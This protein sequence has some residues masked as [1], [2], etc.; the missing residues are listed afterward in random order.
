MVPVYDVR[1][2]FSERRQM[3][4]LIY[5]WRLME[6]DCQAYGLQIEKLQGENV[7]ERRTY[8]GG[9]DFKYR[10]KKENRLEPILN[11]TLYWE[12]KRWESPLSLG[13]MTKIRSLPLK[14]CELF[15]NYRIHLIHMRSIPEE[16]L[17]KMDSDL[18]YV[19]GLMK[20][21]SSRK[22]YEGLIMENQ[23]YFSRIPK[24]AVDVIDVCTSI[25]NIRKHLQFERNGEG[26]E[27]ADMCK[28][29]NEIERHAEKQGIKKGIKQGISQGITQGIS[30]GITQ[31]ESRFASLMEKLFADDRMEDAKLAAA[32]D[33]AR[34]LFYQEYGIA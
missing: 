25:K 31:G 17:Q 23:E 22:K 12:K 14:L 7:N 34:K 15:G 21:T 2:L 20:R 19:L 11:L 4:K 18:K 10:Y 27:E 28:A 32:D 16:E 29:L 9:D 26:E 24:S 6:L 8:E 3:K 13:E 33:K 1:G 30:Q 5:P